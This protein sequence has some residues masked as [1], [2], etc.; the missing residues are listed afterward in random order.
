MI[1]YLYT[2]IKSF[3][4][5]IDA[6]KKLCNEYIVTAC[7]KVLLES[8]FEDST[9]RLFMFRCDRHIIYDEGEYTAVYTAIA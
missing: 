8:G 9:A 2:L 6:G 4:N 3:L 1:Q 5:R 7:L